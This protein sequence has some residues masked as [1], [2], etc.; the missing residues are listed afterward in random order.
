[1]EK[2]HENIKKAAIIIVAS[3]VL[4]ASFVAASFCM[5]KR[6]AEGRI[7]SVSAV[8]HKQAVLV[9]GAKVNADGKPSDMFRDRIDVAI[10][11][12][13]A[14]KADKILV[15]GDHG[16]REYDEVNT[17]KSYILA[18]GVPGAD[19]FLDYAGFDTYDSVY[20]LR[21]IF[22]A[23]SVII[24]TQNYHLPRA[25]YI[26]ESLGLDAVGVSADLHTYGGEDYR[27][28]REILADAKAWLDVTLRS[29]SKYLGAPIPLGGN[30]QASWD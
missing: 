3:A 4:G 28:A 10:E 26:A 27:Q 25:L 13:K 1:M 9:L 14:G 7:Y 22:R 24:V 19:I 20:R 29:R 6:T 16:E 18:R 11:I 30:G 8:A 23:D 21:D 5:V 15:S 12:Y 17:A 2:L